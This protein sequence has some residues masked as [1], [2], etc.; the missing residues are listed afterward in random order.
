MIICSITAKLITGGFALRSPIAL[1]TPTSWTRMVTSTTAAIGM[2]RI[3]TAKFAL[4]TPTM[5]TVRIACIRMATS[6]TTT[7]TLWAVPTEYYFTH[8]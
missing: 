5:T 4:R 7:I 6:T 1:A 3:P 8:I 2:S